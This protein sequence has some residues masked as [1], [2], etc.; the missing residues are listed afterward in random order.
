MRADGARRAGALGQMHEVP[1]GGMAFFSFRPAIGRTIYTTN[2][3]ENLNRSLRNAIET[4]GGFPSDAA[5]ATLLYMAIR[6]A[7][8]R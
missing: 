3:V 7:G 2:A 8:L 1:C 4:R 6:Q 5:A